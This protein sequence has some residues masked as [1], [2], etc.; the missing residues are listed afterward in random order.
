MKKI[1]YLLGFTLST[2]SFA[3]IP[4]IIIDGSVPSYITTHHIQKNSTGNNE[5][6][7]SPTFIDKEKKITFMHVSLSQQAK[8]KLAEAASYQLKHPSKCNRENQARLGMGIVPVFDQGSHGT[9]VTFATTAAID[10]TYGVGDYISQL[11]NLE[12]GSYLHQQDASYPSG[13][14]GSYNEVVF[15]QIR[16]YGVITMTSQLFTGCSG[17]YF[18]PKGQYASVPLSESDFKQRSVDILAHISTKQL[19]SVKNAL[20]SSTSGDALL[21]NVK[22]SLKAG[23]RMVIGTLI[24][25]H[26]PHNGLQGKYSIF[27]NDSWIL[28]PQIENDA[29]HGIIDAAHAMVVIGFDDE[30]IIKGPDNTTHQGVITLRNSWGAFAGD[31]GNYYMSYDYFKTFV[32]EAIELQY[33]A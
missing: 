21:I 4:N 2:S 13:W 16:K 31:F 11:C 14:D 1:L 18:Y 3:T 6:I 24:D 28:T 17:T 25:T 33:N 23:R 27:C 12:L 15:N 20:T 5:T 22:S 8:A 7:T 9:C 26:V 32:Y 30:A 29:K 19:L 10:V